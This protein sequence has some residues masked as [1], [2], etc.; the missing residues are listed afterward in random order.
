MYTV[1]LKD[2]AFE[3]ELDKLDKTKGRIN[4]EAFKL[5]MQPTSDGF[6]ILYK[7]K[8]YQ[9]EID[10]FSSENKSLILKINNDKLTCQVSDE[11]DILLKQLGMD[12]LSAN[13]VNDVR[14]PM[15][16]LVLDVLVDMNQV[17]K[18]GDTLLVL[19]AMKMENNIKSPVDGRI[20]QI[21]CKP[22]TAVEKNDLLI[23]FE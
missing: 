18:K 5:D 9:V 16:G 15:P 11:L 21:V 23:V 7:N 20:I 6:H 12:S 1:Q 13:K 2:K 10:E 3:I 17:V 19:E 8:S 14:A 22:K 4:G